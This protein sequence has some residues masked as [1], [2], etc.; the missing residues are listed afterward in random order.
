LL[1]F[2]SEQKWLEK[3]LEQRLARKRLDLELALTLLAKKLGF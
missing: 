1:G 3:K 2:Q